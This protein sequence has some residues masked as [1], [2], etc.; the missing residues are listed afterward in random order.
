MGRRKEAG[1]PG[2][3]RLGER[4]RMAVLGGER[5]NRLGA[6]GKI[7]LGAVGKI[8]LGAVGKI[9]QNCRQ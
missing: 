5:Q 8:R 9:F 6:V 4:R 7:R 1:F 2:S 3:H